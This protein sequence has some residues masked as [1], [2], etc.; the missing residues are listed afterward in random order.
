MCSCLFLYQVVMFRSLVFL[1][2]FFSLPQWLAIWFLLPRMSSPNSICQ[3]PLKHT[4]RDR[5]DGSV[6]KGPIDISKNLSL[7]SQNPCRSQAWSYMALTPV[8]G[9]RDKRILEAHWL[10]S[11][12]ELMSSGFS[13]RPFSKHVRAIS[14]DT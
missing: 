1:G 7:D 10:V 12:A 4:C 11:L 14:K 9:N 5:K 3:N 13:E 8:V 6:S 2:A